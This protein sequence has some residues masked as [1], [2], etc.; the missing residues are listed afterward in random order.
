MKKWIIKMNSG[1]SF[2]ATAKA[3]N[4]V[5]KIGV[6]HGYETINVFRYIDSGESDEAQIARIDGITAGV[7]PGDIVVIQYPMLISYRFET[8]F[9]DQMNKRGIKPIIFVHDVDSWRFNWVKDGFDEMAYFNKAAVLIVHGKPMADRMRAEGVTAPMVDH[10][11][12]DYLDD[13]HQWD[14]YE[15]PAEDFDRQ[16]V[17]AGNLLKSQFLVDWDL[18]TPIS[19]FGVTD[20][21]LADKLRANP[22]VTYG[23][24]LFQWD[25]V[26][27]M[28]R[29]FG[30]AWDH[31]LE[32]RPYADYTHYNHPHKVSLYLS[33][34]MPVI[35][36]KQSAIAPLIE[37]NHLGF[38][39]DDI[40]EVDQIVNDT[41]DEV[42]EDI[43]EHT[44]RVGRMMRDGW[45]T[46]NA[47]QQAERKVLVPDFDYDNYQNI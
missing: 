16:L 29:A 8:F 11:L 39:I 47:F 28:P 41:P 19:T 15:I 36:S 25:L 5:A 6:D 10:L 23:G 3:K 35:I 2:D 42:I 20:D 45:F 17:M 1:F 33:H 30:L 7:N 27:T 12:L 32:G 46:A 9:I 14:K 40:H 26:E 44:A 24:G 37:A 13:E 21:E 43:L 38:T 31:N 34:G 22:Q 18:E 4:D